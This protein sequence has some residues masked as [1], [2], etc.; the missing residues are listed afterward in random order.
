MRFTRAGAYAVK[1][2]TY[3]VTS[4]E[5]H[6]VKTAEIAEGKDIPS[7]FL[8][9]IIQQLIRAGLLIAHRGKSGG[10][11]LAQPPDK[12]TLRQ[13]LEAIDGPYTRSRCLTDPGKCPLEPMCGFKGQWVEAQRKQLDILDNTDLN[14]LVSL[15]ERLDLALDDPCI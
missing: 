8:F 1:A 9:K 2:M 4:E 11:A 3:I 7:A 10:I 14:F 12:I 15:G 6:M 5:G 13:I